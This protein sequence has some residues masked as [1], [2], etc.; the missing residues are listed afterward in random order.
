MSTSP[1][2]AAS[3]GSVQPHL[4]LV[5]NIFA[6]DGSPVLHIRVDA[7]L[8]PAAQQYQLRWLESYFEYFGV[9]VAPAVPVSDWIGYMRTTRETDKTAR[10]LE[11]A[12]VRANIERGREQRALRESLLGRLLR[13]PARMLGLCPAVPATPALDISIPS[14]PPPRC[15]RRRGRR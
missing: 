10:F 15:A 11:A 1:W 13:A 3:A 14:T 9:T 12:E 6:S 8:S 4:V 5:A 7:L 2:S